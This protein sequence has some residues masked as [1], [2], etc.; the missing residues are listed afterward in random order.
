MATVV[1]PP[2]MSQ[3]ARASR[4]A[5]EGPDRGNGGGGAPRGAG[6]PGVGGP[7]PST[8]VAAQPPK[9]LTSACKRRPIASA[10][11]SLRL[12]GAPDVS[13]CVKML[14]NRQFE[15]VGCNG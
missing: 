2:S 8:C 14:K 7:V 10:R 4:S 12:L 6:G 5:G 1:T 3:S 15:N 11:P 9:P 13:D